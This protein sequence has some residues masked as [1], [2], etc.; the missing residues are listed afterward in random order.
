[1]IPA[2][3]AVPAGNPLKSTVMSTVAAVIAPAES[4][5]RLNVMFAVPRPLAS[6]LVIAGTTFAGNRTA[7]NR[8]WF[9]FAGGV[10]DVGD[11]SSPHPAARLATTKAA[12][13]VRFIVK[14]PFTGTSGKC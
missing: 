10:G 14:S 11:L 8:T 1:M 9:G 7:V 2:V 12:I 5:V 13:Y 4:R 6:A 3:T